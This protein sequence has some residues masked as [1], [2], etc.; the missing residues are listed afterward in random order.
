MECTTNFAL[1]SQGT[2]LCEHGPYAGLA[3]MTDGDLTLYDA[4]YQGTYTR[5]PTGTVSK[6]QNASTK[7][8]AFQCELSPVRSP[9][10]RG[11]YSVSIPPLTNMLKFSG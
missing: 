9:L 2:R 1:P 3:R 8:A 7:V 4:R 10:L 5:A 6:H 11:S